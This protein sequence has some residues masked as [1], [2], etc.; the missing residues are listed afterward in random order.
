MRE[1]FRWFCFKLV[2]LT[3][4]GGNVF[5]LLKYFQLA[6]FLSSKPFDFVFV[7]AEASFAS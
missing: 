4:F 5:E 2:K 3:G 1:V 6:I 7:F